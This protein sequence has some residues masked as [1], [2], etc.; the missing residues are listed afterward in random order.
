MLR[1]C[2]PR[3]EIGISPKAKGFLETIFSGLLSIRN[4]QQI[5]QI[6]CIT[7]NENVYL[8]CTCHYKLGELH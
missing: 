3:L 8:G 1:S 6:Q 7:N 4:E 5:N 2:N